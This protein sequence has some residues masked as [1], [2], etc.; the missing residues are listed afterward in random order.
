MITNIKLYLCTNLLITL[1][2]I[3]S[4]LKSHLRVESNEMNLFLTKPVGAGLQLDN[5]CIGDHLSPGNE[6]LNSDE[7]FLLF[8][9]I[10]C[11][12]DVSLCEK[13]Q[14][15]D[16]NIAETTKIGLRTIQR[17]IKSMTESL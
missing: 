17:I 15:I 10:R 8:C 9:T 2:K 1:P 3:I 5:H 14:I 13:G 4:Q 6:F 16:T 12:K 7:E 11:G